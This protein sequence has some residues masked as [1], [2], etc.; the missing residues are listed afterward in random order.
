[1]NGDPCLRL[2][3][4]PSS[5]EPRDLLGL[6]LGEITATR[7][8]VALLE[9]INAVYQHAEGRGEDA[10]QV[11]RI[12]RQAAR[13]VLGTLKLPASTPPPRPTPVAVA[14]APVHLTDFDRNVL[15]VLI[16]CGGWNARTRTR[17]VSLAA[18][19]GVSVTGL[20][21]V[22]TGLSEY[23]RRGGPRLGVAEIAAGLGGA[24]GRQDPPA[25]AV[26]TAP[27]PWMERLAPE[28]RDRSMAATVKLAILFG[29]LTILLAAITWGMLFSSDQLPPP[30]VDVAVAR[31]PIDTS[32]T[33]VAP[34]NE[35]TA[36]PGLHLARFDETPTFQGQAITAEVAAAADACPQLADE[37]RAID[38]RISI[39]VEPSEAVYR[40]WDVSVEMVA[41]G[42]VLVD[43][44]L[45][46]DISLAI[47]EGLYAASDAPSVTDRLLASLMPRA[48]GLDETVEVWR[49]AWITGML[50]TIAGS[51]GL[52][53]AS[54]E[55]ARAQLELALGYVPAP[56]GEPFRAGA[57]A[58]L[59]RLARK[60]VDG[61]EF[62]PQVY[63]LWEFWIAAQRRLGRGDR[64][65]R[66]IMDVV[67]LILSSS[68]DLARPGPS[69]NV[70]ARMLGLADFESSRIVKDR[71]LGF[72]ADHAAI[73]SRD[74]WVVSSL[75]ARQQDVSWFS[76]DLV[77]PE[78]ADW[79]FR[80]RASD[81]IGDRWPAAAAGERQHVARLRGIE[82]DP[83]I[84]ARWLV[85]F[86]RQEAAGAPSSDADRLAGLLHGSRLNEIA[87]RL[88]VG[89]AD[90]AARQ[91]DALEAGVTTSAGP[92]SGKPTST[93]QPS[94]PRQAPGSVPPPTPDPGRRGRVPGAQRGGSGSDGVWAVAYQ[95][96]GRK[97][98]QRT[99]LLES[100]RDLAGGDLGP[101]DAVTFVR[102]VYHGT[103]NEIRL[104]ARRIL[105]E[106]LDLGSNI[107]VEM[108]DQFSNVAASPATSDM[109]RNLSGRVLPSVRSESWR[110]D[111]RLALLHHA[112]GLVDSPGREIDEA[113]DSIH[114]SYDSRRSCLDRQSRPSSTAH[115]AAI[116][117]AEAWRRRAA[118][119]SERSPDPVPGDEVE[120][121]RRHTTRLRLAEGPLQ[122][123]VAG[124]L[125][126]LD[127]M[128][129]MAVTDQPLLREPVLG[130]LIDST[131]RRS[132]MSHV[133]AQALEVEQAMTRLWSLQIAVREPED[134]S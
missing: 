78:D 118:A 134:Q 116:D 112:L 61:M 12:L 126:V 71:F 125:A 54:V 2:L 127:Q 107:A 103:P 128:A 108:L 109:I 106:R 123:F 58:W 7:V 94:P 14:P 101:I 56:G 83:K 85:L 98:D 5:S 119:P 44:R 26:Q 81:R 46:G 8:E 91:L 77:L 129:R 1:M 69:V 51:R 84:A 66:A 75:L 6:P 39:A 28:F 80:R 52:S 38:R 64:H 21:K 42:W 24:A 67:E 100:L 90:E 99:L 33:A 30:D 19:Y 87:L 74:L 122:R 9:Q 72:F 17:L 35:P 4:L 60:L 34:S 22:M 47:L 89:D 65:D 97:V 92:S 37:I 3:G 43:D 73:G 68:T 45:L 63:D 36:A 131:R 49:G 32:V 41:T 55:Q 40:G 23:A 11:R 93:F 29:L 133:L 88:A 104:L 27:E 115:E 18:G 25:V 111:A 114:R 20:L 76:E 82:V 113:M 86:E 57:G 50:A 121:Q 59:D 105:V 130:V 53:P 120:I 132:V 48:G 95:D 15:A 10:G 79:M 110:V 62:N 96:A 16:G 70:L 117:L 102:A 124:Q 13:S 31:R